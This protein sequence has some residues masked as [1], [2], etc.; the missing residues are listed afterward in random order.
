MGGGAPPGAVLLDRRQPTGG[1]GE[2]RRP[3]A[4]GRHPVSCG[5]RGPGPRERRVPVEPGLALRVHERG[6]GPTLLLLHGFTGS[7]EAWGEALLDGLA[8]RHRVLA[9]DLHG[10]GR[11]DAPTDPARLDMLRVV[12]DLVAV[13]DAAGARRATWIG[14][15]MGGR[16]ALAAA[17]LRPER[18]ERLVLESASPGLATPEERSLR[19]EQDEA[20]AAS[21]EREGLEAFVDRWMAL[22]LFASQRRLPAEVREGER[23]RRLANRPAALAASLRGMGA[24]SQPSFWEALAGVAAPTLLLTGEEDA[25][26]RALADAMAAR[27]PDALRRDVAGAGHAVHLE[28]PEAWLEAV[29]SFVEPSAA[30]P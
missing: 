15:S 17:V 23:R 28:A 20:L 29:R 1:I 21:L 13:L 7:V 12:D 25:K 5:P 26:F 22:P 6:D 10:H 4:P 2:G 18:V 3:A 9:V 27:L 30:A 8:C 24:G 19:R 11:S 16:V 14:Y